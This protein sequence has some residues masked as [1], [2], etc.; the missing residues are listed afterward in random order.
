[1]SGAVVSDLS[2]CPYEDVLGV[3]HSSGFTSI[4]M[5]GCGEPNIDALEANPFQPKKARQERE[6]HELMDK[7]SA[8]RRVA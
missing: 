5:P 1:M 6:V 4:I 7:V 2:F 3:G 8:V